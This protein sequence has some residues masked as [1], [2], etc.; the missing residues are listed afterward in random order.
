MINR[1]LIRIKILQIV[2]AYYQKGSK[3]LKSAEN[4]L[5]RSLHKSYD[6]YHYLLQLILVLT[7]TEQKRLDSLKHKYLPTEQELNPNTRFINNRLTRQL[8]ENDTL[9]SFTNKNGY[10]WTDED[11]AFIRRLLEEIIKSDI[12]IEYLNSPDNYDSDKEFWRKTFK[13]IIS[14]NPELPEILE[15]KSIYWDSDFEII[16]TFVIKTIK[17]FDES[18][19]PEQMLLPMYKSEEDIQFAV[20]LLH[21][22]ILEHTE[23]M[24]LIDS[25]IKNWDLDRIALI[26]LYIMQIALSEIK[27][28][29]SIPLNVSLNEYIDLARFYSTPKSS[30]FI[31]GILDSIVNELKTDGKLFK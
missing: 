13:N 22:S 10:L 28:F 5:M 25:Q 29:P 3:D 6:L 16:A 18:S 11:S 31:N 9:S 1:I 7:D 8:E 21:K 24:T 27:N 23:N 12:Y 2:Y 20:Q 26:D 14:T 17:K 4:E 30:N 15:E 19:K